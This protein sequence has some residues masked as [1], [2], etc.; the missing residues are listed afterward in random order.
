[1]K[2][3]SLC[4]SKNVTK[5]TC[6]LNIHAKN[7]KYSLHNTN[8]KIKKNP[9]YNSVLPKKKIEIHTNISN[10][11]NI[12]ILDNDECLG[13]FGQFSMLYVYARYLEKEY[14]IDIKKLLYSC[15]KHLFHHELV[16]K[17]I[18]ELF[19]LLYKLKKSGKIQ[20]VVMYTS[21]PNKL[22]DGKAGYV[23]FLK[24][25]L[26]IYANTPNLYDMV[27]HRNNVKG[28]KSIDGATLKDIGYVF[29]N[30][31]QRKVLYN[32][33]NTREKKKLEKYI[34]SVSKN[35][36]M[37]DD[38][39]ENINKRM[40]SSIKIPD[41]NKIP[42]PKY[43]IKCIHDVPNF[44]EKLI[45]LNVYNDF[46]KEIVNEYKYNKPDNNDAVKKI[47]DI[48]IKKYM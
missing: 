27:L 33:Q 14:P 40:G 44:K 19:Q 36:L 22:S 42:H 12:V 37:I 20:E 3:C 8:N 31:K 13:Q 11:P 26:E 2:T 9:Q 39:T 10:I 5:A 1:M 41:Y 16:R 47:I 46:I 29:L 7:K 38:K 35:V 17:N 32:N 18:Y 24:K 45:K 4:G 23:Y 21:A 25:C 48:I 6:P 30:N 15:V 34:N 43:F 28:R